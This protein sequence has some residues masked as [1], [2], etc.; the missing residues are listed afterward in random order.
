MEEKQQKKGNPM[1]IVLLLLMVVLIGVVVGVGWVFISNMNNDGP[2]GQIVQAAGSTQVSDLEF[3]QISM[4]I[5][6]N[7][8][9]GP[10]GVLRRVSFD[11]SIAVDTRHGTQ[12]AEIKRLL[13]GAEP[14][15]RD[16]AISVLRDMTADTI[17]SLG[18]SS[19]LTAEIANRLRNEFA[20]NLI[21]DIHIIQLMSQ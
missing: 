13:R 5:N 9:T 18:G 10:D 14:V 21:V 11:F 7:L 8:Q 2:S 12:S 20:T 1:L 16:I 19:A 17:N 3:I 4:P 15:V 6:T